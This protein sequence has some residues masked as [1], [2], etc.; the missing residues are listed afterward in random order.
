MRDSQKRLV[1]QGSFASLSNSDSSSFSNMWSL[2]VKKKGGA[3]Q[4]FRLG[5]TKLI[6]VATPRNV[7]KYTFSTFTGHGVFSIFQPVVVFFF[8]TRQNS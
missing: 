7:T 3:S 1:R 6:N 8:C 2:P 5:G 4:H